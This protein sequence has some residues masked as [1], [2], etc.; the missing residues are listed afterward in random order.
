MTQYDPS[1]KLFWYKQ[2]YVIKSKT[3]INKRK[4]QKIELNNI[5]KITIDNWT[6]LFIRFNSIRLFDLK[7]IKIQRSILLD[8]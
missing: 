7:Y 4:I 2:N 6:F 1:V 5:F 3:F 8:F